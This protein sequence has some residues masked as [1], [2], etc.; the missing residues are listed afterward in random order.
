MKK[1]AKLLLLL[2]VVGMAASCE[3]DVIDPTNENEVNNSTN[4]VEGTMPLR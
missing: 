4:A 2:A 3:K 1:Y